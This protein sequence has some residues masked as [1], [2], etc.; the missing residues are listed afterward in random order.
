MAKRKFVAASAKQGGEPVWDSKK[1]CESIDLIK[2]LNWYSYNKNEKDAAKYLKTTPAVAKD[3]LTLAWSTRMKERGFKFKS[4]ALSEMMTRF[5]VALANATGTAANIV[6]IQERTQNETD[7]II[8]EM[9]GLVDDFGIKGDAKKMNAY[10]WLI[11][12]DVKSIHAN[13]IVEHF[14][15]S[16]EEVFKAAE[17]KDKELAEGYDTYSKS[18]LL[19]ILQCYANII[20]DAQRLAQNVSKQRKP[21]KR[22]PVSFEKKVSKLNYLEKE[23]SL[24]LVSVD[25]V[26]IVG[27]EQVWVYNIKTRKLGVYYGADGSGLDVKGSTLKNFSVDR[28]ISKTLRKPEK[29]LSTVTEGGLVALRRVMENI[30]AKPSKLTGRINKETLILRVS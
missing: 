16:S 18:R 1:K 11:D 3:F 8:G 17:G 27:A 21:R 14:R 7:E 2:A 5:T 13:R 29:V 25:P 9:E 19:N 24:K 22:K 15:A 4:D 30:K 23:D 12:H 20:K 6:N 28:S 26:K 10:Q